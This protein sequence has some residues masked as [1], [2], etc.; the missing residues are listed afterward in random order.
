MSDPRHVLIT[1]ASSGIGRALAM[2]YAR[3]GTALAL[4]GRDAGR[5]ADTAA[6]CRRAGA[7]VVAETVDAVDADR[8]AAWIAARDVES[9]LDLVVANAGV[10]GGTGGGGE[11]AEQVRRILRINIDGVINT[12]QPAIA[13][14]QPRRSGQIAIISSLA[15]YRGFPG[16]PAYC[17]SKAAVRIYG[18]ALR[19]VLHADNIGVS[20][21]C[22]GFVKSA[23]TASNEYRMPLLM[24]TDRAAEIIVRGL[25]RNRGSI[26]FPWP[27]HL[28]AALIGALP[29]SWT[30]PL[31]RLLPQKV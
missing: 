15:A 6:T 16:A 21:V 24:E 20:V 19:G 27:L 26:A 31:F 10:S 17:A 14:M 1:G 8:M 30:D 23:I 2:R 18:Q 28:A 9:P 7:R 25:A 13:C 22:P 11:S 12:V 5:L 29:A 3:L 4:T